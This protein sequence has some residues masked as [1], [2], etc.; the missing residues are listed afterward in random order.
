MHPT[1][2]MKLFNL[3]LIKPSASF[4]HWRISIV[5]FFKKRIYSTSVLKEK[6]RVNYCR[7]TRGLI[8]PW[9]IFSEV[10]CEHKAGSNQGWF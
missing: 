1:V 4:I 7:V 10:L 3:E 6:A 5:C 2:M 9:V 8:L